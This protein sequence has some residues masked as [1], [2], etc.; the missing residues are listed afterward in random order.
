MSSKPHENR[1]GLGEKRISLS[2]YGDAQDM[3]HELTFQFPKVCNAGGFELLRVPEGGKQLDVLASPANGYTV[4]YLIA[5]VHHAKI[6]VRPLQKDLSLD[7][8]KDRCAIK[9]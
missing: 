4:S 7:A 8:L 6:F 1:F 5:L 9:I 2:A 3:Y